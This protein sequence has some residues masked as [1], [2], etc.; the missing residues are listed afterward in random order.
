MRKSQGERFQLNHRALDGSI[1]TDGLRSYKAA[2]NE[3]DCA[4]K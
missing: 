1:T 2:M 4:E 3:L